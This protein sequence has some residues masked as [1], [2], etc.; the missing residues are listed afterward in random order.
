M[1]GSKLTDVITIS[2]EPLSFSSE[3][4]KKAGK[5]VKQSTHTISFDRGGHY[6]VVPSLPK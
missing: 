3:L 6:F 2:R 4:I 5:P 1:T